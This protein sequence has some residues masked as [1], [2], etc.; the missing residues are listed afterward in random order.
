[1]PWRDDSWRPQAARRLTPFIRSTSC[2]SFESALTWTSWG[3][4]GLEASGVTKSSASVFSRA[5]SFWSVLVMKASSS[6]LAARTGLSIFS[7]C[8]RVVVERSHKT[9]LARLLERSPHLAWP[10]RPVLRT[11][12]SPPPLPP[13]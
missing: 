9:R 5:A 8:A 2:L 11:L 10:A 1:M 6:L 4:L 7:E 12:T 3:F 13:S